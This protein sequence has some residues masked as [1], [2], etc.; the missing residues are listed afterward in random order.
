MFYES[1]ISLFSW[2][3]LYHFIAAVYLTY[4]CE[5]RNILPTKISNDTE[6]WADCHLLYHNIIG[7]TYKWIEHQILPI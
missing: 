2:Y 6:E 4:Y 1:N 5:S 3:Y 7:Y